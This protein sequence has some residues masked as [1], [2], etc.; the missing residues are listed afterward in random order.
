MKRKKT[1]TGWTWQDWKF[2]KCEGIVEIP[3]T[4]YT[5]KKNMI[6]WHK[7]LY[8]EDKI[9]PVKVKITIEEV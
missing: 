3:P 7:F 5:S 9:K 6:D 4:I 8:G 2:R 1:L